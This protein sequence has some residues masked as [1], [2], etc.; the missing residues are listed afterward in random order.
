MALVKKSCNIGGVIGEVW[1]V[2]VEKDK[3]MYGG[4]GIAEFLG[5]KNPQK[6]IRDHVKPQWRNIWQEIK[7]RTM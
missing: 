6:A 5:Y 3:F 7:D 2:E 4:H 1:I